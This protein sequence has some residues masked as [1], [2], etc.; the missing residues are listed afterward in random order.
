[1]AL[2]GADTRRAAVM[3]DLLRVARLRV[4]LVDLRKG[5]RVAS[6]DLRKADSLRVDLVDLRKDRLRADSVD[7]RKGVSL[8][9]DMVDLPLATISPA[10]ACSSISRVE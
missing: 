10:A 7:L 4:V 9:V 5:R 1:M 6:V 2:L 8:P 3:V